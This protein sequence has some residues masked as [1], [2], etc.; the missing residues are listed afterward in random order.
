MKRGNQSKLKG[1]GKTN[2]MVKGMRYNTE[3]NLSTLFF[4]PNA[5]KKEK[6]SVM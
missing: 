1:K 6:N 4:L 5:R 2:T 3:N